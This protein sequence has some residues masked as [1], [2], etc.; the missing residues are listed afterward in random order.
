MVSARFINVADDSSVTIAVTEMNAIKTAIR[1]RFYIDFGLIPEDLGRDGLPETGDERPE[2]AVKYLCFKDDGATGVEHQQMYDFLY[3][4]GKE[5]LISWNQYA[6]RGWRGPYL[7]REVY[8]YDDNDTAPPTTSDDLWYPLVV[9]PYFEKNENW[10]TPSSGEYVPSTSVEYTEKRDGLI[11][12]YRIFGGQNTLLSQIVCYGKNNKA[13]CD[14]LR[15]SDGN[16]YVCITTHENAGSASQPVSG[17]SWQEY[18]ALDNT[19]SALHTWASGSDYY[20]FGE[21]DIVVYVFGAEEPV[22]P[23]D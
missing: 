5:N 13:D 9:S 10:C 15:G 14:I 22:L 18:W 11:G 21:D 3:N 12:E 1:D 2:H 7:E 16:T 6:R 23:E 8:A 19:Q 17:A 4:N 20:S